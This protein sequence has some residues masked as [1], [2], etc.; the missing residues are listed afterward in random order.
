L[1]QIRLKPLEDRGGVLE[2]ED[3]GKGFASSASAGAMGGFGLTQMQE[4]VEARGGQFVIVSSLE[5]GT[6]VRAELPL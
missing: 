1:V 6:S 3:N 5:G 4:R 2:I